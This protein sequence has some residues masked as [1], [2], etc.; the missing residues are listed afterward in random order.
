MTQ[1]CDSIDAGLSNQGVQSISP[2]IFVN[3]I[4]PNP[5]ESYDDDTDIEAKAED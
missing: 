2:I 3:A 4:L 5:E 1:C